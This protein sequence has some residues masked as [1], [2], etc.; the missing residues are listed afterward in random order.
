M[1][2]KQ[3]I[4]VSLIAAFSFLVAGILFLYQISVSAEAA[5]RGI[6][7]N[8]LLSLSTWVSLVFLVGSI[9]LFLRKTW[10]RVFLL[11]LISLSVLMV[12]ASTIMSLLRGVLSINEIIL[13]V[14]L[15]WSAFYLTRKEVIG[16]FRP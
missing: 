2:K 14:I 11:F 6:Q 3:P 10:A 5:A 12:S 8:L 9:G 13:L 16:Q 4:G 1:N 7:S 15:L